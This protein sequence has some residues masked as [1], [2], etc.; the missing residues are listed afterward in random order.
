MECSKQEIHNSVKAGIIQKLCYVME[1]SDINF[2]GTAPSSNLICAASKPLQIA[3]LFMLPPGS[4]A[5]QCRP[6]IYHQHRAASSRS[7]HLGVL[8]RVIVALP[9]PAVEQS[10]K[11]VASLTT[12]SPGEAEWIGWGEQLHLDAGL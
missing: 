10:P 4:C 9:S 2:L 1:R 3:I 11:G 12:L 7:A 8:G 5:Q 6:G